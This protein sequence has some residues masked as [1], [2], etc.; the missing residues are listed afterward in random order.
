[1][2]KDKRLVMFLKN[3][4]FIL[5]LIIVQTFNAQ[6]KKTDTL[7][8]YEKVIIYDTIYLEKALKLQPKDLALR[9]SSVTGKELAGKDPVR[10]EVKGLNVSV[11]KKIRFGAELG[12]GLKSSTW[13]K[14]SSKKSSQF[15]INA[16]LWI[17]KPIISKFSLMLSAHVYQWSST[18][19]LDANK[20]DTW[21]NGYYFTDDHQ[22]LLFQ[23]FNNKHTEYAVQLKLL[24][25]W[26]NF[27]PFIGFLA[28]QNL[29][30]MQFLVP[31][32][33]V[34]NKT[35]YFK[36]N[37]VN[38]GFSIGAQYKFMKKF[39]VS[40]EYQEYQ[41]KN[42]SLKNSSFNFDIFKTNNTFAERKINLGI[43]YCIS[44]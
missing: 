12:T 11:S 21:L 38:F 33:D 9:S 40:V 31:E 13:A 10:N 16:G 24:Y 15:G 1:M 18:F 42:I 44:G 7:Y 43:S 25:D 32:N 5:F 8:I 14:E 35:D 37:Q 36:T 6:R 3:S 4:Y 41:M 26:K 22:P 19:A 23:R 2:L 34:L 28:N 29:Y 17:S 39:L 27:R 20:E 30:K